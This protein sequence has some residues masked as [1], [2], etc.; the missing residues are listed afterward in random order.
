MQYKVLKNIN[1]L[2]RSDKAV[3]YLPMA[4]RLCRVPCLVPSGTEGIWNHL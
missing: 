2:E 3:N 4:G 1:F